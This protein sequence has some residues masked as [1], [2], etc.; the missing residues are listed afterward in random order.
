MN[1][2]PQYKI[3]I[4]NHIYIIPKYKQIIQNQKVSHCCPLMKGV[5]LNGLQMVSKVFSQDG[6]PNF[7]LVL[8]VCFNVLLAVDLFHTSLAIV[9]EEKNYKLFPFL[10]LKLPS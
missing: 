9:T 7:F 6:I 10:L 3:T 2:C 8:K 4:P 1:N 5:G